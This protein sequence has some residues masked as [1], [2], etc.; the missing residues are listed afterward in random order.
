MEI[1]NA[2]LVTVK[3]AASITDLLYDLRGVTSLWG[4]GF[5][6]CRIQ[7]EVGRSSPGSAYLHTPDPWSHGHSAGS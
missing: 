2:Q 3:E 6:T 4:L 1:W 5:W 7:N